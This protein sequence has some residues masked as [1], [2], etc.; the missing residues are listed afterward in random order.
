MSEKVDLRNR[1]N[2]LLLKLKQ[3]GYSSSTLSVSSE[4]STLSDS[5]HMDFGLV[6]E[7]NYKDNFVLNTLGIS[8]D[9][10]GYGTNDI[11]RIVQ[12]MV[13]SSIITAVH[14]PVQ[15]NE[16][17]D[18]IAM[19]KTPPSASMRSIAC[20]VCTFMNFQTDR[21]YCE[22]C[23]SKL[24]SRDS[25]SSS[26][27]ANSIE[28]Q[29]VVVIDIS[30]DDD[31]SVI[32]LAGDEAPPP[33]KSLDLFRLPVTKFKFHDFVVQLHSKADE[34]FQYLLHSKNQRRPNSANYFPQLED[35]EQ[36]FSDLP[37]SELELLGLSGQSFSIKNPFERTKSMTGSEESSKLS[38]A[39]RC[40]EVH[41]KRFGD[42]KRK[43]KSKFCGM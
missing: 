35:D 19:L 27:K 7:E 13:L 17:N 21:S 18:S 12:S 5:I 34:V 30:N 11:G 42:P 38:A 3:K 25:V 41:G 40:F 8:I 26:E 10:S 22:I 29:E 39:V 2:S 24:P 33:S 43:G 14:S 9:D 15:Q 31:D 1:Y 20:T 37:D 36:L 6:L 32:D 23:N 28:R 16:E 4:S